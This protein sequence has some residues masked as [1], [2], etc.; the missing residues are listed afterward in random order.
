MPIQS[1]QSNG[2]P[3]YK[4]GESGKCYTYHPN[5]EE[6]RKMALKR[7]EAQAGAIKASQ[8]A[9]GKKE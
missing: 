6:S 5:N 4:Y 9:E 3:G 8:A 2:L 1:C 7:A